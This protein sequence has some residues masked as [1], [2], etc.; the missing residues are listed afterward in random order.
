[1][2]ELEEEVKNRLVEFH[3]EREMEPDLQV[4]QQLEMAIK[5]NRRCTL[6]LRQDGQ[7]ILLQHVIIDWAAGD[8]AYLA[9]PADPHSDREKAV[10]F[11]LEEVEGNLT[12][13]QRTGRDWK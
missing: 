8:E 6:R 13:D 11:W 2:D 7:E 12:F 1:M 9:I 4:R 10:R 5:G 3:P